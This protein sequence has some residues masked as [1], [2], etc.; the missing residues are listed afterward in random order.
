MEASTYSRKIAKILDQFLKKDEWKYV[1]ND[2]KGIFRFGLNLHGRIKNISYYIDVKEDEYIVYAISPIGIDK[3]DIP[4]M[5]RMAEFI[6]RANFGL[7][8]GNFELD[9]RDGELRYKVFVDCSGIVPSEEIIKSSIYSPAL[10]FERYG[11]GI[12]NVI[13]SCT[14]A[15]TA[16]NK[17]EN[18]QEDELRPLLNA[19]TTTS[20]EVGEILEKLAAHFSTDSAAS[21]EWE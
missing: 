13:F 9:F 17:C 5:T 18:L 21:D 19:P 14:A 6:C 12:A 2:G 20:G 8:N 10:M 15:E 4:S 16:I 7:K 1:F 3:T 11:D